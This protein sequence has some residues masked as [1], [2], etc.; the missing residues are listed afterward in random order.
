MLLG[1]SSLCGTPMSSPLHPASPF[2][3]LVPFSTVLPGGCPACD[4]HA[5]QE[6]L[7]CLERHYAGFPLPSGISFN[8]SY[9]FLEDA[10]DTGG[11]AIALQAY[12][13]R[14]LRYR[15]ETTLPNQDLSPQQLFFRSY[16]QV[17]CKDPNFQD[18]Q[19]T[20]SPAILRTHGPVSNS[21]AFARHFHCPPGAPMN[22][23][24]RCQLCLS[25]FCRQKL[26]KRQGDLLCDVD[27]AS[28]LQLCHQPQEV[29]GT[30]FC[31][32]FSLSK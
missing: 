24:I 17:M 16:A 20:H 32:M 8:G 31:C 11:L 18:P 1:A 26:P 12:N 3:A 13:K 28:H 10:A 21:P 6:A 29:I 4:S 22:P 9:S 7:Q 30:P 14:L 19:D 5:L 15:G 25:S 27:L 23:S 2:H